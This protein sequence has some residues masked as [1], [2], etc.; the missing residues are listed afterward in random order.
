VLSLLCKAKTE[1][2]LEM[3]AA[4]GS[5]S[6]VCERRHVGSVCAVTREILRCIVIP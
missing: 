2:T 1:G 4:P 3:E 5:H 6:S